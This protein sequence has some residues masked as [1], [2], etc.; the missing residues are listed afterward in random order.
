MGS[1]DGLTQE[2]VPLAVMGRRRRHGTGIH[3]GYFC[4]RTLVRVQFDYAATP[5]DM[6]MSDRLFSAV[7]PTNSHCQP[8]P[9]KRAPNP[10]AA[11]LFPARSGGGQPP[12]R[13]ARTQVPN[14]PSPPGTGPTS[15]RRRP[16]LA[17]ASV[18]TLNLATNA[19][20]SSWRRNPSRRLASPLSPGASPALPALGAE[21]LSTALHRIDGCWSDAM[22]CPSFRRLGEAA[23]LCRVTRGPEQQPSQCRSQAAAPGTLCWVPNVEQS[24]ATMPWR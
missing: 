18:L 20:F 10:V 23:G 4:Y 15:T 21:R 16:L 19:E 2:L 13:G 17:C 3:T 22:L 14:I 7:Q 11:R 6:Q 8:P 24:R 9:A 1:L 5:Q 12:Q